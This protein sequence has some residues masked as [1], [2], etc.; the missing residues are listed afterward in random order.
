[1][2][3]EISEEKGN[4]FLFG[5]F[6][7]ENAPNRWDLLVGAD[8]VEADKD[9]AMTYLVDHLNA[10]LTM[11]ELILLSKVVLITSDN[12]G[13]KA[14]NATQVEHGMIEIAGVVFSGLEIK[15]AYIITAKRPGGHSKAA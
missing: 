6:L 10:C 14:I 5:L 9:A 13:L 8:W 4:L 11:D 12:P 1:M 3:R 2:E 15:Q 7:R